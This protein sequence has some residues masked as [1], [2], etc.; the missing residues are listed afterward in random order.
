MALL[1][2]MVLI[3][4]ENTTLQF[5]YVYKSSEIFPKLLELY[6]YS[7]FYETVLSDIYCLIVFSLP[8]GS[9]PDIFLEQV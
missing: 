2:S 4:S 8:L 7:F 3:L 1:T 6:M 5:N 9:L